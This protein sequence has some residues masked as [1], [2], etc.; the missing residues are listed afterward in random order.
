MEATEAQERLCE[1]EERPAGERGE[2]EGVGVDKT[3]RPYDPDQLLLLSPSIQDWV[4]DGHLARFVS[5]LVEHGLDLSPIYAAYEEERGF[6]PYDPRLMLKLLLYGYAT[7]TPSSRKLEQRTYDD[8]AVRFLCVDQHPDYR[9]IARFRR[10][11]LE[12]LAELFTQAL[13]VCAKAGLVKLG[14]VALDGTKLRANASRHKAMSYERMGR[15]ERRLEAELAELRAQAKALLE[16]AEQA[17]EAD[18]ARYGAERRGDELPE[19]LARSERRLERIREAKAALEAEAKLK[20]EGKRRQRDDEEPPKPKPKAQ[21]NFTDPDSKIMKTADKSFHQCYNGQAVVD[22]AA[23]VIVAAELSDCAADAPGLPPLLEQLEANIAA[24]APALELEGTQLLADSGFYSEANVEACQERGLDPF[25][26]TG[27]LKHSQAP[28]PPRGGASRGTQRRRSGWRASSG[29]RRAG[30]PTRGARRSSSPSSAR[31]R[32]SRTGAGCS[33]AANPPLGPS[34]ASTAPAT[35]CSSSSAPVDL[36]GSGWKQGRRGRRAGAGKASGPL[37]L[38]LSAAGEMRCVAGSPP[39][40]GC[41]RR[42]ASPLSLRTHAPRESRSALAALS[43]ASSTGKDRLDASCLQAEVVSLGRRS[44]RPVGTRQVGSRAEGGDEGVLVLGIDQ[45]ARFR[46][47]DLRWPS[48]PGRHH[49]SATG[50]GLEQSLTER[51]AAAG[52]ADDP[53]SGNP[54]RHL[55]GG[56]SP[57]HDHARPA[58]E[59]WP[60]RS[61]SDEGEGGSRGR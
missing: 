16:Q 35:T 36:P 2:G 50:H 28:R 33:Y 44:R 15:E 4:P 23:Q 9:S 41:A 39:N 19:E 38:L 8:V 58:L 51:L 13:A 55:L 20:A 48:Y 7:G 3:F 22:E 14:R 21:R 18:D 6:P 24:A 27:R 56:N 47:N 17:D 31:S 53:C 54:G 45:D 46:G 61:V 49:R 57:G 59:R 37:S 25:I 52:E 42:S 26:A 10:R 34:G 1:V 30:P 32:P 12:A 60:Q 29:R 40:G 5:D 11:H 43:L